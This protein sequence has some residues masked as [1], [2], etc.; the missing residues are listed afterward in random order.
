[1]KRQIAR[2]SYRPGLI[3]AGG[4]A[5]TAK[6]PPNDAQAEAFVIITVVYRRSRLAET[7]DSNGFVAE[8]LK[9][10]CRP[11]YCRKTPHRALRDA[12]ARGEEAADGFDYSP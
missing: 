8:Y 11:G 9:G 4:K 12:P 5:F 3:Y 6:L 10:G 1:M 7:P 2:I